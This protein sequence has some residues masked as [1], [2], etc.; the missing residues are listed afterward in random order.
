MP[1]GSTV[2][3]STRRT[4]PAPPSSGTVAPA[5]GGNCSGDSFARRGLPRLQFHIRP[6]RH[7]RLPAPLRPKK[8]RGSLL[9]AAAG[10]IVLA[11]AAYIFWPGQPETAL[12]LEG[13][14]TIGDA[15]APAMLEAFARSERR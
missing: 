11:A 14:T 9:L 7:I 2:V 12:R 8:S 4:P 6:P 1:A 3:A 5:P 10:V 15:L 13:S